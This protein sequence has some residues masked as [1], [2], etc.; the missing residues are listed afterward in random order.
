MLDGAGGHGRTVARGYH[1][2][3]AGVS[4][5]QRPSHGRCVSPAPVQHLLAS[6]PDERL[7]T[8]QVG[9]LCQESVCLVYQA[10][11][12]NPMCHCRLHERVA[13]CL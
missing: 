7:E 13:V 6:H 8:G 12:E 9:A 5:L 11:H 2:P 1:L 4:H 3:A 10:G